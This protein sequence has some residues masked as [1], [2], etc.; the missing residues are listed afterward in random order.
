MKI[1]GTWLKKFPAAAGAGILLAL[2]PACKPAGNPAVTAKPGAA[3]TPAKTGASGAPAPD[4]T[5]QYASLFD[6]S[7]PPENKGRDPFYPNSIRRIP[8]QVVRQ[9]PNTPAQQ[10]VDPVFKLGGVMGGPGKWL[11]VI[12]SN[13]ILSVGQD[14]DVKTPTGKVHIHVVEIGV[15]YAFITVE[16]EPGQKRLDMFQNNRSP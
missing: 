6:S 13:Y 16:G 3:A 12:N 14:A 7:L 8:V 5:N 1:F 11:A 9:N 10:H 2:L 4:F 15:D